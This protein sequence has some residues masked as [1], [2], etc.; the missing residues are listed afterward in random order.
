M[1]KEDCTDRAV[2]GVCENEVGEAGGASTLV[3]KVCV[4][5]QAIVFGRDCILD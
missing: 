1:I 5:A 4:E 3:E 2:L